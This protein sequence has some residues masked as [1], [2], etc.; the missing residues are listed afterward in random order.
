MPERPV[1]IFD[2]CVIYA[3][4]VRDLLMELAV[5]DIFK[6]KWTEDIHAEWIRNLLKNRPDLKASQL[7]HTRSLMNQSVRDCLVDG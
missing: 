2:A 5:R 1:I 4:P 7:E 6:A 3:A